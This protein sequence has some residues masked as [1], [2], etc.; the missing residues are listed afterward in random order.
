[1]GGRANIVS[2]GTG[3]LVMFLIGGAAAIVA[4]VAQRGLWRSSRLGT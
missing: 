3:M 2:T 1:M 4:I